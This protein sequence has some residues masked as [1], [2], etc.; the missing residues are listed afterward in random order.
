MAII[1]YLNEV[2]PYP[3]NLFAGSP[4][5]RAQIRGFCEVIN[6]GIHP[7]QN[8]RLIEKLEKDYGADKG[9]WLQEWVTKGATTIEKLLAQSNNGSP[10]AFGDEITCADIFFYPQIMATKNRFKV[11]IAP[12]PNVS[13]VLANLQKIKEFQDSE[14]EKQKDFD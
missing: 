7:Y 14:P 3:H 6:S 8:L 12:F 1:E 9:K 13:R 2:H 5:R 11:D 10:Y 4:A